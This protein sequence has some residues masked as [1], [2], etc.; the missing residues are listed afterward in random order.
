MATVLP[1]RSVLGSSGV[2]RPVVSQSVT[3]ALNKG[4]Q[5]ATLL[6]RMCDLSNIRVNT[7]KAF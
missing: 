2:Y 4:N 3:R 7:F 1:G 5:K 6:T